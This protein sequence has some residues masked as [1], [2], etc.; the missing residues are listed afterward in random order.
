MSGAYMPGISDGPEAGVE[1]QEDDGFERCDWCE[2][3]GSRS[4]MV[5]KLEKRGWYVRHTYVCKG[6]CEAQWEDRTMPAVRV[7]IREEGDR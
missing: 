4:E 1:T 2:L 3:I 7:S 6:E 5:P